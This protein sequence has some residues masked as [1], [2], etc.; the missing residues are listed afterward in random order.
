MDL[1]SDEYVEY[2]SG[3]EPGFSNIKCEDRFIDYVEELK[4]QP[5]YSYV[6]EGLIMTYPS[7]SLVRKITQEYPKSKVAVYDYNIK[8]KYFYE[9]GNYDS[10]HICDRIIVSKVSGDESENIGKICSVYGY[11]SVYSISVKEYIIT[12]KF[13][14]KYKMD[15]NIPKYLFHVTPLSNVE[16]IR[17]NG[18]MP[19]NK[20]NVEN[21]NIPEYDSRVYFF[22]LN[23]MRLAATYAKQSMHR[24]KKFDKIT[25][26]L[27][28]NA[29]DFAVLCIKTEGLEGK[30]EF[31][32][33]L[34]FNGVPACWTSQN[35]PPSNVMDDFFTFHV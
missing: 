12:P 18:L 20:K 19:C 7:K 11:C 10:K 29:M 27:D 28:E 16:K 31:H 8:L 34:D 35:I 22:I 1:Y 2:M 17:K 5:F 6:Y 21:S 15:G 30:V 14:K 26:T 24:S 13:D 33:D 9:V 3:I 32:A 25:K 4:L 23:D